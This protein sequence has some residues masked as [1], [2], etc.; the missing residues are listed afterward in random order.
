MPSIVSR[1]L[2]I[3]ALALA[4][5][6]VTASPGM[7]GTDTETPNGSRTAPVVVN[8]DKAGGQKIQARIKPSGPTGQ[9]PPI[10]YD[11]SALPAPVR[12]LREKILKAA[13]SGEIENLRKLIAANKVKLEVSFGGADDPIAF[14]KEISSDG[15][16]RDILADIIRVFESGYVRIGAGTKNELYIWPYHFA[17]PLRKLTP[18]QEVELYLLIPGE[19]RAVMEEIGGYTGFRAAITP[20]GVWEFFIGGD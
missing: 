19:Y 6:L 16:G 17:Y 14:W 12:A 20:D 4:G 15:T 3:A 11:P 8:G 1:I 13:R 7:A 10:S 2:G 18:R 9:P 5:W